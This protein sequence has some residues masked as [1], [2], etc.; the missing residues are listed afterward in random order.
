[1]K[2]SITTLAV[3]FCTTIHAAFAA[4]LSNADAKFVSSADPSLIN[5]ELGNLK[6][7][8]RTIDDV[9]ASDLKITEARV[10]P[11][12]STPSTKKKARK[13]PVS[14]KKQLVN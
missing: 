4:D 13:N 8:N 3:V 5:S 14:L 1:M 12:K 7:Y 6:K 10:S 11:K 9:I 2:K